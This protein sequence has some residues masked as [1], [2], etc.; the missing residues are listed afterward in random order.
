MALEIFNPTIRSESKWFVEP[1]LEK[2]KIV[3][4]GQN[5]NKKE[6]KRITKGIESSPFYIM[7]VY[8]A[9]TGR[10]YTLELTKHFFVVYLET[11]K[12]QGNRK[13]C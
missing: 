1:V 3:N 12:F 10:E 2:F 7:T 9:I 5:K 6:I 11:C 13:L 8:Y 4:L